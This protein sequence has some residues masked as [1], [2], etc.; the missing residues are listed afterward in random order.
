MPPR[1][2]SAKPA[3]A[4]PAAKSARG[5]GAAA[6][7]DAPRVLAKS[8]ALATM[9][10]QRND[11]HSGCW[12]PPVVA[13]VNFYGITELPPASRSGRAWPAGAGGGPVSSDSVHCLRPGDDDEEACEVLEDI[14]GPPWLVEVTWGN[15]EASITEPA[16]SGD[17]VVWGG[18]TSESEVIYMRP[19]EQI[20]CEHR[21]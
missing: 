21:P 7:D 11:R 17:R 10:A 2:R 20:A 14:T 16:E 13:T 4:A 5:G 9:P 19:F 3:A 15:D 12:V 18:P 6:A 1:K 8:H